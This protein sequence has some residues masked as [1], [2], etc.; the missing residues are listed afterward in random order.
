MPLNPQPPLTCKPL[1]RTLGVWMLSGALA[2]ILPAPLAADDIK[3]AAEIVNT[4]SAEAPPT[5]PAGQPVPR[6]RG[7]KPQRPVSAP[8]PPRHIDLTIHFATGSDAIDP[9]SR[10]QVQQI[11]EAARQLNLGPSQLQIIGHTD[12]RG[13][14]DEN[15]TLSERR[16]QA[17]KRTLVADYGLPADSLLAEGKGETELLVNPELGPAD[18]AQN[19]RVELRLV[20]SAAAVH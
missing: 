14:D 9:R 2:S 11:A 10:P 16:A 1:F 3:N 20:P 12:S 17:V 13:P 8:P 15:L 18:L 19:R 7:I 5:T 4:L 6:S